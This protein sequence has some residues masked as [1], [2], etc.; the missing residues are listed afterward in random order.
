MSL[1]ANTPSFTPT[2]RE[3]SISIPVSQHERWQKQ[4]EEAQKEL[5]ELRKWKKEVL[6]NPESMASKLDAAEKRGDR[7]AH[8]RKALRLQLD[9]KMRVAQETRDAQAED[10]RTKLL[11]KDEQID[12]LLASGKRAAEVARRLEAELADKIASVF[13]LQMK[14]NAQKKN[15]NTI[16]TILGN[17][18]TL[19]DV[20]EVV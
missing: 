20:S 15:W 6:E 16:A 17:R 7:L 13:D 14:S 11:K 3:M 5:R 4:F 19:S 12:R 10:L 18:E 2:A 9:R 8:M 1:N